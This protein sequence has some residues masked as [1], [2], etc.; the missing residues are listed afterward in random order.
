MDMAAEAGDRDEY[1]E[2]SDDEIMEQEAAG[3]EDE[4]EDEDDWIMEEE[5]AEL[6]DD[7][8]GVVEEEDAEMWEDEDEDEDEAGPLALEGEEGGRDLIVLS[9]AWGIRPSSWWRKR[10]A[11]E[12]ELEQAAVGVEEEARNSE[13]EGARLIHSGATAC[14]KAGFPGKGFRGVRGRME[15]LDEDGGSSDALSSASTRSITEWL[16]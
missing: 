15:S 16:S 10:H 13:D 12:F 11:Q 7:D 9:A 8:D 6:L 1:C 14:P 2:D 3:Y 5:E 4:D